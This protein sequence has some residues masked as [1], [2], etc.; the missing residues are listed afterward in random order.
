MISSN[1][2]HNM[3]LETMFCSKPETSIKVDKNREFIIIQTQ[4]GQLYQNFSH[5]YFYS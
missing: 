3:F 5:L 4:Q 1:K 2:I